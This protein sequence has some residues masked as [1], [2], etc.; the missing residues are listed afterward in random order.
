MY[1]PD[2]HLFVDDD[3]IHQIINLRRMLNQPAYAPEPVVQGDA[4]W[5]LGCGIVAW[6]SVIREEDGRLRL[7]YLLNDYPNRRVANAYAESTTASTGR[8]P[9][10]G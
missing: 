4:E 1:D 6:G 2:L 9:T 10:W 3:R 7:W 8:S 5:E